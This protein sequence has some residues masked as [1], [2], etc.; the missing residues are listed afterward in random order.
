M[1]VGLAPVLLASLPVAFGLTR[2]TYAPLAALAATIALAVRDL[3]AA[4]LPEGG[5]AEEP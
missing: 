2:P 3:V 1:A 5:R 4:A